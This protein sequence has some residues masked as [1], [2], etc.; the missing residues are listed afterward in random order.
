MAWMIIIYIPYYLFL[1]IYYI[2]LIWRYNGKISKEQLLLLPVLQKIGLLKDYK[3]LERVDRQKLF[4]TS[5]YGL[6]LSVL[7]PAIVATMYYGMARGI[8]EYYGLCYILLSLPVVAWGIGLARASF[9]DWISI[10][11]SIKKTNEERES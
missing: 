1:S 4:S 5:F 3:P 11:T 9:F 7:C 6:I 8:V 2:R 10:S